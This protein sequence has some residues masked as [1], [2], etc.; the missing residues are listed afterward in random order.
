MR[1]RS[2][3]GSAGP[4]RFA[5]EWQVKRVDRQE[6]KRCSGSVSGGADRQE[7]KASVA[8]VPVGIGS[9]GQDGRR[10][11]GPARTDSDSDAVEW[12]GSRRLVTKV[13]ERFVEERQ[14]PIGPLSI[15]GV[16]I[17]M[18]GTERYVKQGCAKE[19]LESAGCARSVLESE[20]RVGSG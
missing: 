5:S 17:G 12:R 10:G 20:A 13:A 15:D 3:T 2:G 19:R 9:D 16:G 14:D 6:R 18:A 8:V 7:A 11:A 4:L 1:V